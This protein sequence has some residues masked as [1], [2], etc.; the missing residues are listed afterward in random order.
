MKRMLLR[1][2][3]KTIWAPGAIPP[4]EKKY[5]NP[6]KRFVLPA[7]DVAMIIAGFFAVRSGIPAIHDLFPYSVSAGFGYGFAGV[8]A[9]CFIGIAFPRR[10]RTELFSKVALFGMLGLY[11]ICLRVLAADD[12][13]SRD[14]ISAIVT[15]TM[16]VPA[17]RLW[18]L[19]TE[20]RDRR[21]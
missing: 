11:L 20:I 9:A 4:E 15:A 2:R 10:W 13:G 17:L 5:A 7:F 6:L 1:L 18:I 3:A 12:G 21:G 14:F 16:L 19:G 8:A